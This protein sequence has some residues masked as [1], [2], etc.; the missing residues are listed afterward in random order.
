MNQTLVWSPF[1]WCFTGRTV[2]LAMVPGKLKHPVR[3]GK[4][5]MLRAFQ[6]REMGKGSVV[7][8][9]EKQTSRRHCLD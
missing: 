4:K 8:F 2:A 6:L 1:P 7:D 9:P 5:G 3:I